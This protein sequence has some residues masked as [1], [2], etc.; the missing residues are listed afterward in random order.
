MSLKESIAR[1]RTA[2]YFRSNNNYYYYAKSKL[3]LDPVYPMIAQRLQGSYTPLLD[4]GCGTGLLATYL[5]A[6]REIM[7]ITALDIDDKKIQW[8]QQH[9][10]L[11]AISFS[12]GDALSLPEHHGDVVILDILHYFQPQDLVLFLIQVSDRI[13]PGGRALIRCGIREAHWRYYATLIEEWI[14][15]VTRWIPTSGWNFPLV[16]EVSEPF[17]QRGFSMKMQP[18]WGKTPFNSYLFEFHRPKTSPA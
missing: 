10:Q 17:L 14:V 8:A 18:M 12:V 4:I 7:P 6:H 9:L 1:K 15:K 5:R 13:A 2:S 3:F 11:P 16:S